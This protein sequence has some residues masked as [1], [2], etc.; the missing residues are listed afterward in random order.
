MRGQALN[1]GRIFAAAAGLLGALLFAACATPAHPEALKYVVHENPD[2]LPAHAAQRNNGED[3]YPIY[4]NGRPPLLAPGTGTGGSG[5]AG[6][7]GCGVGLIGNECERGLLQ[8]ETPLWEQH[9]LGDDGQV[10][11]F[12]ARPTATTKASNPP[13]PRRADRA[14]WSAGNGETRA[15]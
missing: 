3:R 8:S 13:R 1:P 11:P 7:P 6:G 12:T 5:S 14:L 9:P 15:R 4:G 10:T 2:E